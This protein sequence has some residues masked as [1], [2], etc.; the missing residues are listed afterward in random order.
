MGPVPERAPSVVRVVEDSGR[1]RLLVNGAPFFIKGAGLDGGD[2]QELARRGG[3]ALRTWSTTDA[4][5]V[6]DRAQRN[7]LFVAMGIEVARERHGFDYDDAD[8]VAR[9]LARV[10]SEVLASKDH[11]ALL[12]WVV[13]NELNLEA[14]NPAVWDAVNQMAEMIHEVDP[15]H[16]VMTTLAGMDPAVVAQV[17][18][19]AKALDLIGIQLYGDLEHLP[20]MLRESGW[21]GPYVVTEWGPTGHWESPVTEWGAPIEDDSSRKASLLIKRYRDVIAADTRQ[22]L[23]SFVFLWGQK[24]ERTPTWYGLFTD[25]GAATP[26]VDAMQYLWTGSWPGNRAPAIT[27][28]QI[29][30]RAAVDGIRLDAGR[31]YRTRVRATDPDGDKLAYRWTVLEESRSKA[32]GGDREEMPERISVAIRPGRAGAITFEAPAAPGVYRL[33]VEVV[34]SRGHAAYAN[35]P[36]Q[37]PPQDGAGAGTRPKPVLD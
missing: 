8:A 32:V 37:V 10:R 19:R 15:N 24:Q 18:R 22:G 35:A 34:D 27:P 13:G 21:T 16:P 20:R 17:K 1:Y 29:D 28:L 11:P 3:N 25:S 2:P 6:L 4:K 33:F 31:S 23:G 5:A 9:Q 7:G 26:G 14:T 30:G 12:M 36:F